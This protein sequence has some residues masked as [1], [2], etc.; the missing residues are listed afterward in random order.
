MVNV[1]SAIDARLVE[2]VAGL[3]AEGA[4]GRAGLGTLVREIEAHYPGQIQRMAAALE[5]QKAS[6]GPAPT[7]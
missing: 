6:S 7:R 5:L 1:M 2:L 4:D 3:A